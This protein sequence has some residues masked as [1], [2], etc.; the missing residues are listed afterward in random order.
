MIIILLKSV[1]SFLGTK[2]VAGDGADNLGVIMPV[3]YDRTLMPTSC[4]LGSLLT[5]NSQE[6][7]FTI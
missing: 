3:Y 7:R 5:M 4:L 2:R 6:I 1:I